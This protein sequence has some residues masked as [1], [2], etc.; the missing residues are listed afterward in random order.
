[1]TNSSWISLTLQ[2]TIVKAIR[3]KT[4][5]EGKIVKKS[6]PTLLLV[7]LMLPLS[8]LCFVGNLWNSRSIQNQPF[9]SLTHSN[10]RSLR[11]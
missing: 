5:E 2:I 10:A 11:E 9:Q 3:I 6:I 4:I 7:S 1:M 8:Y